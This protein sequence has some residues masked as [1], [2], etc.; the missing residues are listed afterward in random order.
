MPST[1]KTNYVI[2]G[3]AEGRERL[4][5]LSQIHRQST[6]DLLH[7]AGIQP[8]MVCL[9]VGCGGGDVSFE[10]A[11]LVAPVGSVVGIDIDEVT[12][13]IAQRE[14]LAQQLDNVAFR[15]VDL[16][17]GEL[18]SQFDFVHVRFVLSH[19]RNPQK[20]LSAIRSALLP[21]GII[22]VA[23]T[24]FQGYF[25]EPENRALAHGVDLYTK[26]IERRGADA[27]IGPRLPSML[28]AA[29]FQNVQVGVIQ[30][31][32][33]NGKFK[34]IMPLTVEYS[35]DAIVAEGLASRA[36]MEALVAEIYEFARNPMTIIGGPRII[37]SWGVAES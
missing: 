20:L 5:L 25:S 17:K 8:G 7:R 15:T 26:T 9:D 28:A 24:Q 18:P 11:R 33:M 12:I 27:N 1:H 35:T 16:E 4:R 32:H 37:Q 34:S 36:E 21:G 2:R 23:D 14:A 31:A 6:L 30:Q 3:G 22:V 29:G 10:L 13:D 19:L